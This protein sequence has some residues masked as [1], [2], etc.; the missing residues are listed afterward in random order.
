MKER[1][2][3][4]IINCLLLLGYCCRRWLLWEWQPAQAETRLPRQRSHLWTQYIKPNLR[5][6]R[7]LMQ[8]YQPIFKQRL[9]D[10]GDFGEL[11]PSSG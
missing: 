3:I 11:N 9:S 7:Q 8:P 1:S 2:C 10:L 5:L 6:F 4:Y